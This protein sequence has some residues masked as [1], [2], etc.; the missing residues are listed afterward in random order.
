MVKALR[1]SKGNKREAARLL[2]WSINT[3]RDR[4]ERHAIGGE[5]HAGD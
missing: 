5:E 2:G 1:L 3:L 4:L